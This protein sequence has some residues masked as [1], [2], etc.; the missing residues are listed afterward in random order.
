M[1]NHRRKFAEKQPIKYN[2][3]PAA[4]P[5]T[6]EIPTDAHLVDN[7]TPDSK[8]VEEVEIE[9]PEPIAIPHPTPSGEKHASWQQPLLLPVSGPIS[10]YKGDHSQLPSYKYPIYY[11]NPDL[12]DY[13]CA[14]EYSYSAVD[15][16]CDHFIECK[17]INTAYLSYFYVFT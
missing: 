15:N 14:D 4:E 13:V 5:A 6:S 8:P 7:S 9:H 12:K 10:D 2:I 17:V 1:K 11:L 16:Q 3:V